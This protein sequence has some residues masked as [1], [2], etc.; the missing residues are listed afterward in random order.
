MSLY[1]E[2]NVAVFFTY[3]FFSAPQTK[4]HRILCIKG[5]CSQY[6][7]P[8]L[9]DAQHSRLEYKKDFIVCFFGETVQFNWEIKVKEIYFSWYDNL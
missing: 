2:R 6:S 9:L 7:K 4:W 8:Q 1:L 5:S 3:N